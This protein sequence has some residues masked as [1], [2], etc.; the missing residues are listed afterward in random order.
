MQSR[1][2]FGVSLLFV[3]LV[4]LSMM[5]LPAC[6]QQP[7]TEGCQCLT[8]AGATQMFGE[9]NFERC[10]AAPCGEEKTPNGVVPKYCFKSK[11]PK[12]CSC[13]TEEKAKEAGYNLCSGQRIPCGYDQNKR[14][15]YCFS[16]PSNCP[17]GCTCLTEEEAKKMGYNKFCGD[18]KKE[19]GRDPRGYPKFCYQIPTVECPTGCVCASKEEAA[20]KGLK[21]NCLDA[22]GKPII[23][24]TID[25]AAGLFRYCFKT[26]E[27]LRCWYDYS[28]G[29][30]V[31][32][33][34]PGKKCQLNTVIRDPKTMKVT[35]AEC[36][37][38]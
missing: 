5:I 30:C 22:S 1:R 15:L 13:L 32:G 12:G 7:C 19:C 11:C 18:V 33:C 6:A 26:P 2:W 21:E 37:C 10:Q 9:G 17:N 4:S 14:P 28:L 38:K 36:H 23:C 20:A 27:P 24:G 35:F 16:P 8:V 29:K 25:A 3:I 31:G 34:E